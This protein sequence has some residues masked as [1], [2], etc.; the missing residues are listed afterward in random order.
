M[1]IQSVLEAASIS[2]NLAGH[3]AVTAAALL[4]LCTTMAAL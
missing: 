3:V 1:N 4:V 2:L